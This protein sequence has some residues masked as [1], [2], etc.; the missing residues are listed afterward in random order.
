MQDE[1]V[2]INPTCQV[3]NLDAHR[4]PGGKVFTACIKSKDILIHVKSSYFCLAISFSN[5]SL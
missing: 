3:F 5:P 2:A 4:N 1:R